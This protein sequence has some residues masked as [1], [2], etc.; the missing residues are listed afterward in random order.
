M[1]KWSVHIFQAY[2]TYDVI[3]IKQHRGKMQSLLIIAVFMKNIFVV[4]IRYDPLIY[5]S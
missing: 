5:L 3:F 4:T 1:P 2:G